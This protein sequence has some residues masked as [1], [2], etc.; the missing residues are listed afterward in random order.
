MCIP[1]EEVKRISKEENDVLFDRFRVMI[2]EMKTSIRDEIKEDVLILTSQRIEAFK[3]HE[4]PSKATEKNINELR[5]LIKANSDENTEIW[6]RVNE[7]GNLTK[8]LI[9][10][11]YG[12]KDPNGVISQ[13]MLQQVADLHDVLVTTKGLK[14]GATFFLAI[15]GAITMIFNIIDWLKKN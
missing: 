6:S 12:K 3:N 7:N 4:I 15:G 1:V 10:A 14:V 8:D 11:V 2:D 5:D 9:D 13:G